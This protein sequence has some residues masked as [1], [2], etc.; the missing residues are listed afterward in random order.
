MARIGRGQ[1]IQPKVRRQA[2]FTYIADVAAVA[3]VLSVPAVTA[4]YI[5]QNSASVAAVTLTLSLPAVTGVVAQV[6]TADVA[7]VTLNLS[8]SPL[9]A[10]VAA[11]V[12]PVTVTLSVPSV[13]A[14]YHSV[15]TASVSPV[16][17]TLSLPSVSIGQAFASVQPVTIT[18][19]NPNVTATFLG[20]GFIQEQMVITPTVVRIVEPKYLFV[21]ESVDGTFRYAT[22]NW[23]FDTITREINGSMMVIIRTDTLTTEIANALT[24]LMNRVTIRIAT[25]HTGSRGVVY[26][27]GYIPN[28][29]LNLKPDNQSVE[30]T[31]F[32][33]ASRL[34]DLPY[35][36]GTTTTIDKTAGI[37]A[38][39]LAKD[40]I[41]KVRAIDPNFEPN[42]LSN[43]IQDSVDTIK[44]KFTLQSAGDV[45]NKSVLLAFDTS[46]IW[47]WIVDGDVFRFKK[48]STVADHNFVYGRDV[49]SFPSFA[50]DLQQAKN[51]VLIVY[52]G[53]DDIKRVADEDN[54]ALYG[55]RSLVINE[56][57]ALDEATAT[58]LGN[59]YLASLLPPIRT[60]QITVSSDYPGGI[61]NIKPGDTCRIDN[62]HPDI[63]D[64]I[65]Q[66][67]FITQNSY[68][69]GM[70]DLTLSLKHPYI[71]GQ[72]E[73]IRR[74]V[75]KEAVEFISAT[76]YS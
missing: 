42:Y 76:S 44:D 1:P 59:A 53:G 36:D 60:I 8:L 39:N 21:V 41:D 2:T 25:P 74:K 73:S 4:T 6:E 58:E 43:S 29:A 13:T 56:Q 70:V 67:M 3:L 35:R 47:H 48:N 46:R 40:V 11:S 7:P 64:L 71:Q 50:E 75:E 31:A 37:K 18:L 28:R 19:T 15:R 33:F 69:K 16:T 9:T 66:N 68:R 22:E 20:T 32:G 52:N 38:S 65:T 63:A 72:I 5:Y 55:L 26:F 27:K 24:D 62:L 57:T 12:S 23:E 61:E 34:F 14:T 51:E 45:L 10:A 54:I 17:L 49:M 30:I